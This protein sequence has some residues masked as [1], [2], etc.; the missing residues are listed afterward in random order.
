MGTSDHQL[1]LEIEKR[2]TALGKCT[3]RC[4]PDVLNARE[5][6]WA[7]SQCSVFAG[8]RT[9]STIAGM[10]S[11]T[12]TISMSYSMKAR[13]INQDVFDSQRYCIDS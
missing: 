7:I 3:V 5:S 12:P 4:L 6:K 9:H 13:G 11:A 8:A 2:V 1:L 10:S